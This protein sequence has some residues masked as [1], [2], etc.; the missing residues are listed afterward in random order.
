MKEANKNAAD[1]CIKLALIIL[2]AAFVI[3]MVPL[4]YIG[5]YNFAAA[6][7]FAGANWVRTFMAQGNGPI[8]SVFLSV[9]NTYMEWQ[10]TFLGNFFIYATPALLNYR[11][12]KF[13]PILIYGVMAFSVM[14][15]SK[16]LVHTVDKQDKS[17]YKVIGLSLCICIIQQVPSPV[18][19][20]Y[21]WTGA[22]LYT[23]CY[24]LQLIFIGAVINHITTEKTYK[25]RGRLLACGLLC[26]FAFLLGGANYVTAL[27]NS[28]VT[29]II[30]L[31][32]IFVKKDKIKTTSS[33]FIFSIAGL[34]VNVLAPGNFVRMR[35]ADASWQAGK[36]SI[37][38]MIKECFIQAYDTGLKS[39]HITI[40]FLAIVLIPIFYI[41]ASKMKFQFKYPLLF[42]AFN[43]C[44]YS[45]QYAPAIFTNTG[46]PGRVKNVIYF[47]YIWSFFI[48][49]FYCVGYMAK[50]FKF[51]VKEEYKTLA[52]NGAYAIL[53]VSLVI[54]LCAMPS[55]TIAVKG[56][57][58]G[59]TQ[60]Y[61]THMA[62]LFNQCMDPDIAV[63]EVSEFMNKPL[64]LAFA[65]PQPAEGL[66]DWPT[67]MIKEHYG[68]ENVIIRANEIKVPPKK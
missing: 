13:V 62:S 22:V 19:G 10:G 59:T 46:F 37:I 52:K 38:Q 7:D 45:A 8:K 61:G 65:I 51:A 57:A 16:S 49:L 60:E 33:I 67:R 1:K 17:L 14:F 58:D 29:L 25:R 12:Y 34:L 3:S 50:H 30:L 66:T 39:M 63:P 36:V 24:C 20:F 6:D 18:E 9:F 54:A 41:I 31:F 48:G 32:A 26:A 56:L 4:L 23:L 21:W 53:A 28:G 44:V 64:H 47:G 11:I 43:F 68:K 27:L 55:S 5:R 42:L 15:L 2:F 40:F 35:V